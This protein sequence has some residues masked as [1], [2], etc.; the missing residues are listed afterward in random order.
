[1]GAFPWVLY[2][3][4]S[5]E[6]S[7]MK[8][9]SGFW[10]SYSSHLSS[11]VHRP[12]CGLLMHKGLL[13]P[14]DLAGARLSVLA[15]KPPFQFRMFQDIW[16]CPC[17]RHFRALAYHWDLPFDSCTLQD[18]KICALLVFQKSM[19]EPSALALQ[20]SF[21]SYGLKDMNTCLWWSM[22]GWLALVLELPLGPYM[23]QVVWIGSWRKKACF[24][25]NCRGIKFILDQS[26]RSEFLP[27]ECMLGPS[28]LL[29]APSFTRACQAH[30]YSYTWMD[31]LNCP[32]WTFAQVLDR[33]CASE[34]MAFVFR[35]GTVYR[36][37]HCMIDENLLSMQEY[38]VISF[39]EI[40]CSGRLHPLGLGPWPWQG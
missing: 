25:I 24:L 30:L 33:H 1:M 4:G 2:N 36:F 32:W 31:V 37:S 20:L 17:Q 34:T 35:R 38:G 18:V 23:M 15:W 14:P 13:G 11:T 29:G 28:L 39:L 27:D 26:R 19:F 40:V 16:H 9:C 7:L 3:T 5:V 8:T 12:R 10:P 22:L 21:D 6:L